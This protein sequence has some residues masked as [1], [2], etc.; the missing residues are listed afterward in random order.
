[1]NWVKRYW[2]YLKTWRYHRAVIKE[3]NKLTDRELRDIGINRCDID[4]LVWL[5]EDKQKRG[6]QE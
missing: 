5:E 2:N 3:L 1:M 4:R 6:K